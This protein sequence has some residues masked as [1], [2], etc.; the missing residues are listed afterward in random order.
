MKLTT[1]P[2]LCEVVPY[3]YRYFADC[4]HAVPRVTTLCA[5]L[6]SIHRTWVTYVTLCSISYRSKRHNMGQQNSK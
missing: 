3:K 5:V 2:H 6:T 1:P 4:R